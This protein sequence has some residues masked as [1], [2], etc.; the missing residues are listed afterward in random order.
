MALW[1]C[2]AGGGGQAA[3]EGVADP[4]M[5]RAESAA[6]MRRADRL[7]ARELDRGATGGSAL[8]ADFAR[9]DARKARDRY[10]RSCMAQRGQP[11]E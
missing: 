8:S 9:M 7:A 3:P 5:W 4:D 2:S 11:V 6:C 10:W 1:A